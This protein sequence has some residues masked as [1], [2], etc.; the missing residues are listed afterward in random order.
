VNPPPDVDA[1]AVSADLRPSAGLRASPDATLALVPPRVIARGYCERDRAVRRL[2]ALADATAIALALLLAFLSEAAWPY[3]AWGLLTIPAWLIINN[4]YGLYARDI[5]RMSHGTVDDLPGLAH[6]L[7]V[8]CLLLWLYYHIVPT[9]RIHFRY[10]LVFG[11]LTLL[12]SL[13]ARSA[14]RYRI[15][16]RLGPERVLLV[17]DDDAI[18]VLAS[19]LAGHPEYGVEVVGQIA[20][21]A[22]EPASADALA[23]IPRLR[24]GE[25]LDVARIVAEHH[26]HR[27][28]VSYGDVRTDTLRQLMRQAQEASVKVAVVPQP[29]D[30]MG[31]SVEVDNVEGLTVFGVYPPVLC[32]S[33]RAM[34]RAMDIAG[35]LS[36]MVLCAPLL[37][38]LFSVYF[39]VLTPITNT[40]TRTQEAE[41][42][43]FGLN[44]SRQPDGFAQPAR[45]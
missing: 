11:V 44:A 24:G 18:A 39:F 12:F 34:K 43:V 20:E 7:L 15:R 4:A 6:A 33:A 10:I 27:I 5:K 35:S 13:A 41:A 1:V 19:K 3:V 40:L 22:C 29:F 17:G 32:R 23:S 36:L 14:V 42:D 37:A 31:P 38:A 28:V 25:D 16:R 2:L 9:G 45:P 21:G 26:V 30:V 8:G